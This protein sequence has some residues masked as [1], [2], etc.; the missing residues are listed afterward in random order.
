MPERQHTSSS[1]LGRTLLGAFG[2]FLLGVGL[3]A[4]FFSNAEAGWLKYLFSLV[5]I[6]LGSNALYAARRNTRAWLFRIGPL[7]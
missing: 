6:A 3:Y 5:F 2:L 7:P 1:L 4:L